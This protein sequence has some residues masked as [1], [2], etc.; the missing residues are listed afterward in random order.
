VKF[1]VKTENPET[2]LKTR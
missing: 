1:I 2:P